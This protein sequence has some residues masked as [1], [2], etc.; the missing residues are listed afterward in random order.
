MK[1]DVKFY[2]TVIGKM[3]NAVL[4]CGDD[5]VTVKCGDKVVELAYKEDYGEFC[6][7]VRKRSKTVIVHSIVNFVCFVENEIRVNNGINYAGGLLE[8]FIRACLYSKAQLA[9]GK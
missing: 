3:N 1:L 7:R 5:S 4:E 6:Y 9:S 8:R 2:D